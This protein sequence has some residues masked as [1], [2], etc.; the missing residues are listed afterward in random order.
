[1]VEPIQYVLSGILIGGVYSTV[2]IAFI[3]IYRSTRVFNFAQGELVMIGGFLCWSVLSYTPLPWWLAVIVAMG[4]TAG[5]GLLLERLVIRPLIGQPL[6]SIIM[7]TIALILVLRGLVI[8]IWGTFPR[9][10]SPILGETALSLGPFTFSP[11][12]LFGLIV[13][14][15]IV[16]GLWWIF[17]KT[18]VGLTMS[19]VAEDHQIARAL[20]ISVKQS[21]STAWA[22]AGAISVIAAITWL[23][24]RS[25]GLPAADIG[26]RAL[27]CALLAGLQ[28]VPGAL[29]AGIIVGIAESLAMGYVDP[30]TEGGMSLVAPFLIMLLVLMIRP[31]G[32][33]GWKRIERL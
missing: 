10:I 23:S 30:L 28:S 9:R 31:E 27:P 14:G 32:L 8:M 5:V 7:V 25:I 13:A 16:V 6:F 17:N 33:F 11:S 21:M 2:A 24:G 4:A 19:A 12:F 1:M 29:V 18:M 20:G 3:V 26:L 15:L 22:I